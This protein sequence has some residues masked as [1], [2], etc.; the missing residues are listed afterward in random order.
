MKP[1]RRE[2][3]NFVFTQNC[4]DLLPTLMKK[5]QSTLFRPTEKIKYPWVKDFNRGGLVRH[6]E[7]HGAEFGCKSKEEYAAKAIS[8]A[9]TVDRDNCK[10]VVDY[11]NT[12]YKYNPN[13]N[14]LA[15]VSKDGYVISYRHYGKAFWYKNKKGEKIWISK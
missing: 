5:S 4:F 8:F 3:R 6:F 15:E 11:K 2:D 12:T 10:S 9:N 13:T 14:V 7:E 1:N